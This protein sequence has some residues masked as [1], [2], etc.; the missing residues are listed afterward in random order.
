MGPMTRP[1]MRLF[2]RSA[3]NL[4]KPHKIAKQTGT[5]S[6]G[7]E[8]ARVKDSLGNLGIPLG[9]TKRKSEGGKIF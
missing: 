5:S 9:M 7:S 3:Q 8:S 1:T 4:R 2:G 6:N